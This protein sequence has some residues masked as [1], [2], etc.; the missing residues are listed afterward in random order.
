MLQRSTYL[1]GDYDLAAFLAEQSAQLFLKYKVF[2]LTGEVPRTY[3][4]RDLLQI[5]ARILKVEEKI[6]SYMRKNRSLLIRL[7]EAYIA[8]RYLF[9]KYEREETEELIVFAKELIEFV[10]NL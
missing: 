10:G 8:S 1:Q 6:S 7:E 9:R 5:L 3:S 2:V 4:I